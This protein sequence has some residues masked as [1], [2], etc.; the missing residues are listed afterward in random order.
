MAKTAPKC[1]VKTADSH[2][3]PFFSMTPGPALA[4]LTLSKDSKIPQL[5]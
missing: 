5:W 4:D 2:Q 1:P 3:P